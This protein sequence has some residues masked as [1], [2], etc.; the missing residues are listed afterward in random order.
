[1]KIAEFIAELKCHK[2]NKFSIWLWKIH[3][4]SWLIEVVLVASACSQHHKVIFV[5]FLCL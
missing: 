4:V 2:A 5:G 1:M 3:F